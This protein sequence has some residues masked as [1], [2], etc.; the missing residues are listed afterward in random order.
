M[1]KE[2]Y[3]LVIKHFLDEEMRKRN[4]F[5]PV[6][7]LK[8][9]I[10][11]KEMRIRGLVPRFERGTIYLKEEMIDLVDELLRFPK[12]VTDDLSDALSFQLSLAYPPFKT[13][14]RE[15]W[16]GKPKSLADEIDI[17]E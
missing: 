13:K 4:I 12:A 5:L 3:S 9:K 7:E 17:Y 1:E 15:W 11:N 16:E 10:T 14:V 2:K 8:V 6:E